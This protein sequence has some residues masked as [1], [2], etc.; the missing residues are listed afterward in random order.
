MFFLLLYI[1][2]YKFIH[3]H[4]INSPGRGAGPYLADSLEFKCR[5]DFSFPNDECAES[6]FLVVDR[7]K[8]RN[9]LVVGFICRPPKQRLY[10]WMVATLRLSCHPKFTVFLRLVHMS[11]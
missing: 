8:E 9:L 2:G 5:S 3:K 6:V 11:H 1:P 10:G 4:R 7:Q